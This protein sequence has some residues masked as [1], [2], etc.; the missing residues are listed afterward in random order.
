MATQIGAGQLRINDIIFD[1]PPQNIQIIK[2][3][4][5]VS[6]PTLRTSTSTKAKTGYKEILFVVDLTFATGYNYNT[7]QQQTLTSV[8]NAQLAPLIIQTRKCPFAS[9]ENE[10]IRA[11]LAGELDDNQTTPRN[12][13]VCIKTIKVSY[14]TQQPEFIRVQLVLKWFNYL[15]YSPNFKYLTDLTQFLSPTQQT[16]RPLT[17][18]ASVL[19]QGV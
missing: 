18:Q 9:I 4:N 16:A 14:D 10:K 11:E 19:S 2:R 6:I 1:V 17:E 5:N 15:P 12:M 3:D 13:A 7:E 8:I